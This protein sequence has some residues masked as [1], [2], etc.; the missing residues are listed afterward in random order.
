M[1][2]SIV[3]LV[4]HMLFFCSFNHNLRILFDQISYII[5]YEIHEWLRNSI[6]VKCPSQWW[7]NVLLNLR[8]LFDH[9]SYIINYEMM[10]K[11]TSQ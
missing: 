5:N 7:L 6:V 8:I 4:C 9:I 2:Y 3:V 11:R 10:D 1:Y